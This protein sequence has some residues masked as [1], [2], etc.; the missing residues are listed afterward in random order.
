MFKLAYW[1]VYIVLWPIYRFRFIGREHL[2][3]GPAII[4]GNHT[5]NIDSVMVVLSLGDRKQYA[6][7]AKKELFQVPLLGWLLKKFG[8]YPVSRGG[9]DISAV[10]YSLKALKE[11]EKLIIFPEGTRVKDGKVSEPKSGASMLALK[12]GVPI[13]PVHITPGRKAF[14]GC[15]LVYGTPYYPQVEGR[16]TSEDYQKVTEEVMRRIHE[17]GDTPQIEG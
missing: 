8:A 4:C 11:G 12:A 7:M 5:A 15:T 10:K 13:I 16:P 6:A 14:R 9:N 2:V 1:I 3:Q 17:L